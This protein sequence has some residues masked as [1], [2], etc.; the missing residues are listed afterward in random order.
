MRIYTDK[1]LVREQYLLK[2]IKRTQKKWSN[3]R[4]NRDLHLL[5]TP[6]CSRDI[7]NV[8]NNSFVIE[9]HAVLLG[10]LLIMH[11][12]CVIY[13]LWF[14]GAVQTVVKQTRV[15]SQVNR[16]CFQMD[17]SLLVLLCISAQ[18]ISFCTSELWDECECTSCTLG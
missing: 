2:G 8:F 3:H 12:V 9:I 17:Q 14:T 11:W 1:Q 7:F 18:A 5:T 4:I 16:T 6:V 10:F 15:S 13:C